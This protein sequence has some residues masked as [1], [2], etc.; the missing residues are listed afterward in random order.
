MWDY[1]LCFIES[2]WDLLTAQR[3]SFPHADVGPFLALWLAVNSPLSPLTAP[4]VWRAKIPVHLETA[5]WLAPLSSHV[6]TEHRQGICPMG[7][8]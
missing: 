2:L 5:H 6:T 4:D 1:M 7:S 3:N 8:P